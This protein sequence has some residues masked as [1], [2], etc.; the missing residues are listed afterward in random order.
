MAVFV[1]YR[2][3]QVV[4]LD[5]TGDGGLAIQNDFKS[6]IRSHVS[7]Y[8]AIRLIIA[9]C[10]CVILPRIAHSRFR[11]RLSKNEPRGAPHWPVV[12]RAATVSPMN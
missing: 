5:P 8:I 10:L 4:A 6:L 9:C 11:D 1:P 12:E 3:L 7:L 2:R